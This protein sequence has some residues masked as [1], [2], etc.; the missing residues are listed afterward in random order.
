MQFTDVVSRVSELQTL[1]VST[2]AQPA[3]LRPRLRRG[4]GRAAARAFAQAL[5]AAGSTARPRRRAARALPSSR[6]PS[7]RSARP[8]SRPARTT[9]LRS[10]PTGGPSQGAQAG[11]PWCAYFAS[12]AAQQ[13]GTPIG[14][15]GQGLGSV[16]E[17]TDWA[18]RTGRY[19]P[20]GST[21]QPGDLILFG[22]DH[23]G[24]VESVN[25]DG[26]LTTVEGNS[27]RPSAGSSAGRAKPPASCA[28]AERR[29]RSPAPSPP[30]AGAQPVSRSPVSSTRVQI[31]SSCAA[32]SALSAAGTDR[33]AARGADRRPLVVHGGS[34]QARRGTAERDRAA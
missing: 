11:E 34:M 16:A 2:L 6:P 4:S 15:A 23:V 12:W 1:A 24:I 27:T 25:P 31:Q 7:R 5:A 20:A 30:C 14:D 21:P 3:P 13:A 32:S 33:D 8:S 22:T 18:Q 10:P 26:S 9:G 28:W 19:L 17:I 29:S